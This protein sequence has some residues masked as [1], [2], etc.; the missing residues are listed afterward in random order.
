[1]TDSNLFLSDQIEGYPHPKVTKNLFGH[2]TAEQEF[3]NCFKSGKFHHGWLITGS[4]GIGKATFAWRVAKFLLTQPTDGQEKNSLFDNS[5]N[6]QIAVD[7]H[8]RNVITARIL[9][10]S[11]P[12]LAIIR[13]SYDEKRKTFRSS[14]RVDEIRH[15]KSSFS[16]SVTDGGYR[17]AIVDCA[18]DLNINAANA[19]LKTLE[20][21]PKNTVFLLICHNVHS[22]IPTIKSRCRELRLNS[23]A[24][25]D[26]V[27][28]LKQINLTIPEQ[29]SEIYSLL[30]SGSVGNSIR[31]IQ[32]DGASIYRILLSFLHQLPD[33][34]GFELEKFIA[35][36][37]GNK[38]K[39]RLELLIELL[40]VTVARISKAG[41]VGRNSSYYFLTDEKEIFTKLCPDL[42]SAKKWAQLAQTQSERL[43]D[44]LAVNLDP[45]SMI[46]DTF[47]QIEDCAR[48]IR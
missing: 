33:L 43:K 6:K 14:I 20:E 1:M 32:H 5:E 19:L 21:P 23:L 25:S 3:I 12:R 11:E 36:F 28:A 44:G 48:A 4:K 46:L 8:L 2:Q 42:N 41:I 13:K 37:L 30:G 35:T 47:F 34:N 26:L 10:E 24:D 45:G 27:N 16:L 29:D 38:N 22:L 15:L 18:D 39:N 7:A 31:L 9:A 17:V 40:S